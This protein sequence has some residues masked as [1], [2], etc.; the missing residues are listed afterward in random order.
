MAQELKT[1]VTELPESRVR[2]EVEVPPA[3][4]T[5]ALESAAGRIARDMRFP[6]FRKGKVPAPVVIGRLGREA[7]LDEAVRDRL[8]RWYA[9]AIRE[10]H[11]ASI[12]EPEISLGELPAEREPFTFSF[13]I[14][15]RP[16]ATLGEWRGLEVA[17]REAAVED[18]LIDRQIEQARERL[19]RLEPVERAAAQGDF[20]VIDYSGSVDGEPIEGA[21]ARAQLIELGGGNL[22]PGFEEGLLGASAGDERTLE[23]HFPDDYGTPALAGKDATFEVTVSE[24]REKVLPELDDDFALDAAGMDSL[25]ELREDLRTKLLE[26]DEAAVEREFRAA[27]IDAAA[28]AATVTVPEQLVEARAQEAWEQRLHTLSHRGV[29]KDAYLSIIGSTEEEMLA[30]ARPSAERALRAEAVIAAIVAAEGIEPT[31]EE[32][33]A[34]LE[35]GVEP[36]ESGRVPDPAKLL[37]QLRRSGRLE[38]LRAD[39]ASD[40]ALDRLV[41]AA[42]A[43]SPERAAAREKL[44]TPGS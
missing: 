36:D 15:V 35:G 21:Q 13:E 2:V 19:A 44:W 29:S 20:L 30:D 4:V 9:S 32:L 38:D 39:V 37:T 41:E 5:R 42:V 25:A 17:R 7:V 3:E 43:I 8:G 33:L 18:E 12:G 26:A 27:V 40:Q 16:T 24:V 11:V 23:L 31:D 1:T 34:A 14:G 28:D 10:A 22:I 6:G